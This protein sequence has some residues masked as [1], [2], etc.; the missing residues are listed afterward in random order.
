MKKFLIAKLV[1]LMLL[2]T[3]SAQW[4]PK[5]VHFGQAIARTEGFYRIG[6]LPNRLHNPGDIRTTRI[7]YDGQTGVYHGYA[8]FRNDRAGFQ[9]LYQLLQRVIDGNS[10]HYNQAM[11]ML[12]FAKRYAESPQWPKTLCK[13]LKIAPT[14]T[15]EGYF[16]LA[17]RIRL[18]GADN[19]AIL[20]TLARAPLPDVQEMP[21]LLASVR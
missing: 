5:V 10:E 8:V 18:T 16:E 12:Q 21:I 13:I 3:A 7:A 4:S 17:P 15:F 14:E 11:T 19:A 1:S 2:G 20:R 6:T 9:A